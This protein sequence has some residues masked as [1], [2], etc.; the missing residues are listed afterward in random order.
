MCVCVCVCVCVCACVRVMI[1]DVTILYNMDGRL[2]GFGSK[3]FNKTVWNELQFTDDI[4][5]VA[6][7]QDDFAHSDTF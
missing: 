3:S 1:N 6:K 5:M 4:A 7:S 2:L